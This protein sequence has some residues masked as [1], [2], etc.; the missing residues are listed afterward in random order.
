MGE[1]PTFLQWT[2]YDEEEKTRYNV[3]MDDLVSGATIVH[4]A[5]ENRDLETIK[6]A[7]KDL[8]SKSD[9]DGETP[10]HY[11]TTNDDLE[12][13]KLLLSKNPELLNIKC[14]DGKTALELAIDYYL[15]YN[16]NLEIITFLGH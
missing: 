9:K 8:L 3:C 2:E 12:I 11:A 1:S 16:S 14:V 13:C 10:L 15:E 7:S 5:V 6:N 4:L